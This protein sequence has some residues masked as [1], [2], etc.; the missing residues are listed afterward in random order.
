MKLKHVSTTSLQYIELLLAIIDILKL[1][2]THPNI[3]ILNVSDIN[4][5]QYVN[6]PVETV[7]RRKRSVDVLELKK[8]VFIGQ[9]G[10]KPGKTIRNFPL[11]E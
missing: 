4:K 6:K 1:L 5:C 7:I 8:W 2:V 10:D 11:P 3:K 9:L